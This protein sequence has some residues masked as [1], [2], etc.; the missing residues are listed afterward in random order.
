MDRDYSNDKVKKICDSIRQSALEPAQEEANK[1]IEEARN[2]AR[3][4]IKDAKADAEKQ[5]AEVRKQITSERNVFKASLHL[6]CKQTLA[7]LKQ[8][9]E[10]KVFNEELGNILAS[11]IQDPKVIAQFINAVTEALAKEGVD[12]DLLA[13]IPEKIQPQEVAKLLAQNTLHRLKDQSLKFGNIRGGVQ[14]KLEGKYLTIDLS[15]EALK[16]LV[17]SFVREDYRNLIFS[18]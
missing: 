8:E 12:A 14:I 1:I 10:H 4:I 15:D 13:I 2:E 9:I 17:A 7:T 5:L 16:D 18:S 3:Q 11:H 6:A